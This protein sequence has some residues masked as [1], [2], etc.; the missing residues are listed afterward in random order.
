M[1]RRLQEYH[2][3]ADAD[4]FVVGEKLE[5][6][7][8]ITSPHHNHRLPLLDSLLHLRA[9]HPLVSDMDMHGD[10]TD[11]VQKGTD[12]VNVI[13]MPMRC[14][15]AR[16]VESRDYRERTQD[17]FNPFS[18]IVCTTNGASSPGSIRI[19]TT[20]VHSGVTHH[21][22]DGLRPTQHSSCPRRVRWVYIRSADSDCDSRGE[23]DP[24]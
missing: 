1:N 6:E 12:A 24:R 20:K 16:D 4:L 21:L 2:T 10:V 3:L 8:L 11:A 9:D 14:I 7:L 17:I 5:V 18:V 15:D 22:R 19:A 13:S 23:G